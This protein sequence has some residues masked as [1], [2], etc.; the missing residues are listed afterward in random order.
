MVRPRFRWP[1]GTEINIYW[2]LY[3]RELGGVILDFERGGIAGVPFSSVGRYNLLFGSTNLEFQENG[4]T[5][6]LSS[7]GI[8]DDDE[9]TLV[10]LQGEPPRYAAWRDDPEAARRAGVRVDGNKRIA[11]PGFNVWAP[12]PFP[13]F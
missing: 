12:F 1:S 5:R 3:A 7:F 8:S 10:Y 11:R 2:E 6:W 13:G 4:W 9:L